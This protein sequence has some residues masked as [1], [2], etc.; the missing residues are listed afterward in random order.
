[1]ENANLQLDL[2]N[3]LCNYVINNGKKKRNLTV[4]LIITV[5]C[6]IIINS[7]THI[8]LSLN[9]F[10]ASVFCKVIEL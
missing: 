10:V 8:I 3:L 6:T 4:R 2:C 9:L 7:I 1:M 5:K